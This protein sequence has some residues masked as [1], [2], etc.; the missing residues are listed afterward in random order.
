MG[1][2]LAEAPP[3]CD[4]VE[5]W[6]E[7]CLR[8]GGPAPPACGRGHPLERKLVKRW[9]ALL[10]HWPALRKQGEEHR[11]ER[12]GAALGRWEGHH[13]YHVD[14]LGGV[15]HQVEAQWRPTVARAV[16]FQEAV[17]ALY[18]WDLGQWLLQHR[19]WAHDCRRYWK[20]TQQRDD[21]TGVAR[22]G[23]A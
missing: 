8:L 5:R 9:C 21:R 14:R 10:E 18:H 17:W 19:T 3:C 15:L 16:L 13:G 4:V 11:A 23:T 1:D 12:Y 2:R 20:Q 22:G 7:R 6:V